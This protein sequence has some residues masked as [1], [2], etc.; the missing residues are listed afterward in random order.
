MV[1]K[2][3]DKKKNSG[4]AGMLSN[5]SAVK[6]KDMS[7]KELAEELYKPN[8]GKFEK[9]KVHSSFTDYIWGTDLADMQ[10]IIKFNNGICCLLCVI[11]IFIKYTWVIPLK[12]KRDIAITNDFQFFLDESNRI[13]KNRCR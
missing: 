11:N 6:N 4:G 2:Y 3:F 5:K 8:V 13:P 12:D 9:T 7:N 10:L 1:Y